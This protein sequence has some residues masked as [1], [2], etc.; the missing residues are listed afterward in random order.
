MSACPKPFDI[1]IPSSNSLA[2]ASNSTESLRIYR[3]DDLN[4]SEGANTS[5]K[6]T[7][8]LVAGWGEYPQQVLQALKRSGHPTVVAAIHAHASQDLA[9]LSDALEWFGVC[10]LGRMQRFF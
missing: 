10:K 7:F 3:P 5:P 2:P 6:E 4:N 1:H 8:G 9:P